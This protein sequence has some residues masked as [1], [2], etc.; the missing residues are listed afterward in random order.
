MK[1]IKIILVAALSVFLFACSEDKM[2]EINQERNNALD[3]ETKSILPDAM[4]KTAFETTGTDMA[5]YATVYIEHSAGTW[6]QSSS[7]D[8]RIGQNDASLF[9]NNWNQ[10]Y[11]VMNELQKVLDKTSPDGSEPDN[12]WARGIAQVLMAY[13]LAVATDMWGEVPWTEALQGPD[14][15]QPK[16]DRQ[17]EL[18]PKII[19]MLDEAIVNLGQTEL[20]FPSSDY[21]YGGDES[22][23]IKAA[24]SLKARYYIHLIQRDNQAAQ[25]ALECIP[26]GFAGN[27]DNFIFAAYEPTASGENPWYQFL[28]DRSHLSSGQTLY[29]MMVDRN[30]PRI[31][32]YFT[33]IE[34]AYVPAPNGTA[35]Q[36][37]GGIYSTS[38]Q[39]ENGQTA[40]TPLMTFHELKFIEAE[41][42]FRTGDAGWKTALQEA[43]VANFEYHGVEGGADYYTNEV[44]PLLTA[45]NELKEIISQKYIAFYEFEAI[46]AYNDY[47]RTGFPQMN[48]PNNATA[49][50][51][52]RFPFALSEVSSNP[53]NVPSIDVYVNKVW[54]A[55]GDE[56]VK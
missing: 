43:V 48:N 46:E 35:N 42:K 52:N 36:T 33:Q 32:A 22:L 10:L 41:A 56:L 24:W 5:W 40:P 26:N 29:D 34:G 51:V 19:A 14:N 4:L 28:A 27:A 54:W 47:R 21:I 2:D 12:Y 37:Q 44:D 38:L 8:K 30:D 6:A 53:D 3:V 7:A 17:S 31:A 11:D 45:G 15:L 49:G 9:N 18:Y 55:G 39:T 16:Y 50:F 23:W 1:T 13:N 20:K 25:K